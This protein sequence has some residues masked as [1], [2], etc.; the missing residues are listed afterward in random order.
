MYK[1]I[2]TDSKDLIEL[3]NDK[4]VRNV[5][6]N[7]AKKLTLN[8]YEAEE[9][10]QETYLKVLENQ[11]K[12]DK[13]FEGNTVSWL[14]TIMFRLNIDRIRKFSTSKKANKISLDDINIS[15]NNDNDGKNYMDYVEYNSRI[16]NPS[17]EQILEQKEKIEYLK[18]VKRKIRNEM[19]WKNKFITAKL[20]GDFGCTLI[21]VSKVTGR[22]LNTT[23]VDSMRFREYTNKYRK[24]LEEY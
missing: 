7:Y 17:P 3:L 2:Q 8:E 14:T 21:E 5:L 16:K 19:K 10:T 12:F 24:K 11:S 22:N 1:R 13:K 6:F 4:D 20:R 23:K 18:S 15:I 9:L